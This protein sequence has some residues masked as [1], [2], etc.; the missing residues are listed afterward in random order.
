VGVSLASFAALLDKSISPFF[1]E[2]RFSDYWA[3]CGQS[4]VKS[5]VKSIAKRG[6][7]SEQLREVRQTYKSEP[8]GSCTVHNAQCTQTTRAPKQSGKAARYTRSVLAKNMVTNFRAAQRR[9]ITILLSQSLKRPFQFELGTSEPLR[10]RLLSSGLACAF[11]AFRLR[12]TILASGRRFHLASWPQSGHSTPT[13]SERP[14]LRTIGVC[15]GLVAEKCASRAGGRER[16]RERERLA[17]W[18]RIW[19]AIMSRGNIPALQAHFSMSPA[20]ANNGQTGAKFAHMPALRKGARR[21][22]EVAV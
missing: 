4:I 18:R 6:D 10:M 14:P 7:K 16:E 3:K 13:D 8:A 9:N 5:V 15:F 19:N 17:K 1:V 21:R 11:C 20:L 2:R 22:P 12:V